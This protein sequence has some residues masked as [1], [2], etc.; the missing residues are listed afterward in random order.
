LY[1]D[2]KKGIFVYTFFLI[3]FSIN[4]FAFESALPVDTIMKR[5]MNAA[6]KYND[7]VDNY[8]A[9][10]YT[11]T[12]VETVKKNLLYKYTHL[13]PKFVLH[14]PKND[15]VLIETISDF[16]F[17][18]PNIICAGHSSCNGHTHREKRCGNDTL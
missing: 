2:M 14:D 3:I 5:A 15:E 17:E 12:Y 6:E 7:L 16:R 13:I 10:V 11:R 18:Y 4:T 1:I 8:S 9:E